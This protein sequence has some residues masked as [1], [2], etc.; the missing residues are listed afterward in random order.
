MAQLSKIGIRGTLKSYESAAGY[1]VFGKGDFTL[2]AAQDRSMDTP[3][4]ESLFS[5]IYS[6]N[7]GSNYGRWSDP[8]VDELAERALK[9][10]SRDKRKQLYWELQRHIFAG[11]PAAVPVAWVEGWFFRDKKVMGTSR[12]SRPTTTTPF[13]KVWLRE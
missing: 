1:A 6:T 10:P 2:I 7:A 13:M 3:D 11:A 9:E 8:K 12:R 5:V 4:P